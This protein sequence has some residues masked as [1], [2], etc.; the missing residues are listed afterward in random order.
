MYNRR[1]VMRADHDTNIKL[2]TVTVANQLPICI[3]WLWK[4]KRKPQATQQN[5]HWQ[6]LDTLYSIAKML[7]VFDLFVKK[8]IV[9]G[10]RI[11]R[12]ATRDWIRK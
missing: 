1:Q 6:A 9:Q 11:T 5:S 4:K 10:N 8:K 7:S 3:G 12:R 2:N